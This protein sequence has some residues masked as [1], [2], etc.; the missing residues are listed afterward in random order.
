MDNLSSRPGDFKRYHAQVSV[1]LRTLIHTNGELISASDALCEFYAGYLEI[2]VFDANEFRIANLPFADCTVFE[3]LHGKSLVFDDAKTLR[4]DNFLFK[5]V[6]SYE[7]ILYSIERLRLEPITAA[8]DVLSCKFE[9]HGS[10]VECDTKIDLSAEIVA[11]YS[12]TSE[13]NVLL[14]LG[15][16]PIRFAQQYLPLIGCP[17]L[18]INTRLS[19]VVEIYGT[20]NNTGGGQTEFGLIPHWIRYT[21]PDFLLRFQHDCEAIENFTVMKQPQITS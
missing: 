15:P 13:L 12:P 7:R 16:V 19:D 20:P 2:D 14:Y 18:P 8:G 9:L 17:S 3:E 1:A 5:P 4:L 10:G 11:N 21:F 6:V